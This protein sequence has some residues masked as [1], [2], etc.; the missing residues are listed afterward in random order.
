M[1]I[2][3]IGGKVPLDGDLPPLR[4][5]VTDGGTILID[6]CGGSGEF[7]N[8]IEPWIARL[9]ANDAKL[10][11]I[12][13][14]DALFKDLP[15]KSLRLYALEQLRNDTPRLK[16]LTLGKGRIVF[17][18]LDIRSGLLGTNTW[19]IP[20]YDTAPDVSR[21]RNAVR[22]A[23][24]AI[25]GQTADLAPADRR[26]YAI[27]DVTATVE[28]IPLI[29]ASILSKKLAAGLDALVMDIKVGSGAFTPSLETATALG[30]SLL[31]VAGDAGLRTTALLT[32]MNQVLGH[33]VG[34][35]LEVLEA[36]EFLTG[37]RRDVRLHAVMSALASELLVL[38]GL[39]RDDGEGTAAVDKALASGAAAERFSRMVKALG[40]PADL[41][42]HPERRLARAPVEL[43]VAPETAGVITRIDARAVGLLVAALG[44]GRQAI[45]DAIDPAVGRFKAEPEERR[46]DFRH[47]LGTYLRL[48]AFVSQ[49]VNYADPDLEKLYAFGRLLI[50]QN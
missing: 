34:N 49:L 28:S 22:A 48:Y 26:L 1:L 27:R 20:G 17:S 42:E 5:F 18:A 16:Q 38:G 8:A 15:A 12:A 32:E 30:D 9:V 4:K 35:T 46:V 10:Q 23:G 40:G 13:P 41:L 36:V 39:A 45:A 6:A 37:A 3:G 31:T 43:A 11:L 29:T 50:Q 7:A 14:E 33:H 19:G 24:C 2:T 25:V 47:R 21:F 44:G